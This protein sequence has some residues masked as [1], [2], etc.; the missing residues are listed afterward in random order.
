MTRDGD[1]S[2]VRCDVCGSRDEVVALAATRVTRDLTP[3]EMVT[4]LHE[5]PGGTATQPPTPAESPNPDAVPEPPPVAADDLCNSIEAPCP[6]VARRYHPRD[7]E[8]GVSFDIERAG[9]TDGQTGGSV[10]IGFENGDYITLMDARLTSANEQDAAVPIGSRAA[11][12]LAYLRRQSWLKLSDV[13]EIVVDGH[14][15]FSALATSDVKSDVLMGYADSFA[16]GWRAGGDVE[17]RRGRRRRHGPR[18]LPRQG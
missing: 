12:W 18:R 6:V 4:Y 17:L 5:E 11:D 10:G 2:L 1:A 14:R 7:F 9:S 16:W 8:P 15:G 13:H 3:D